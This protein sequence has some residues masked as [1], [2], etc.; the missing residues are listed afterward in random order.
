MS[1]Q[2]QTE[3][4]R[5]KKHESMHLRIAVDDEAVDSTQPSL[6][7]NDSFSSSDSVE[8]A[9]NEENLSS[10]VPKLRLKI[11]EEANNV[12]NFA[13]AKAVSTYV[14]V[15]QIQRKSLTALHKVVGWLVPKKKNN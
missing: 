7:L 4:L 14:N 6:N 12:K 8:S 3:D 9:K 13:T 5:E 2:N 1:D 15:K 10:S 11:E